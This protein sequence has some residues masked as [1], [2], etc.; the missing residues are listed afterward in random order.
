MKSITVISAAVALAVLVT[1]AAIGQSSHQHP[2]M[3]AASMQKMMQEMMPQASDSA[4]TKAFKETH[5][6]MM[7]GMHITY[8]GESDVDFV[9]GMIAHHQGAIDMA[10]VQLAHGKDPE[11]RKL[12]ESIIA[13]Q[14]RE[15]ALMRAWLKKIGK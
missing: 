13:D 4:S 8:S 1:T 10:K 6:K 12:A 11:I 5:M 3:D 15:I 9:R 7:A 2:P 14:E